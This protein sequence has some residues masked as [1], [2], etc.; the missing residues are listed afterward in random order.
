MMWAAVKAANAAPAL[1]E[2]YPARRFMVLGGT[3]RE[4]LS[5]G[6]TGGD[7]RPG[8]RALARADYARAAQI[9]DG[10]KNELFR[11]LAVV[12]VATAVLKEKPK[13]QVNDGAEEKPEARN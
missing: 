11:G 8:F 2:L 7:F 1:V 9:A 4:G 5:V 12:A 13:A 3:V 6:G 10:F